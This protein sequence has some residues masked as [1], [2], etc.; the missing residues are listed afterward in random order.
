MKATVTVNYNDNN[1]KLEEDSIQT[2]L[3]KHIDEYPGILKGLKNQE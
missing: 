1:E 2:I 3:L